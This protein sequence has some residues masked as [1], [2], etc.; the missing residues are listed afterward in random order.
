MISYPALDIGQMTYSHLALC[1]FDM[2]RLGRKL[3]Y[4]SVGKYQQKLY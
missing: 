2:Q 1:D 3:T 4:S